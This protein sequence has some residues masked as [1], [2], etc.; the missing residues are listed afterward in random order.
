MY[1]A[2][3]NKNNSSFSLNHYCKDLNAPVMTAGS[4]VMLDDE[5]GWWPLAD[6]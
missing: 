2:T 1:L 4:N 5:T 3:L 6:K